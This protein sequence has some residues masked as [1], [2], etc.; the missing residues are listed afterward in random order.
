MSIVADLPFMITVYSSSDVTKRKS[1]TVL[2]WPP[3][4]PDLNPIEHLWDMVE[5]ENDIMDVEMTNL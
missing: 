2:K 5:R 4:S 3:Q 1:L